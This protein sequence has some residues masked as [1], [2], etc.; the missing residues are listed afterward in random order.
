MLLGEYAIKLLFVI[1]PLLTNVSALPGETWTPEIVSF[2]SCCIACLENDTV[3]RTCCRL[4]L[5][6]G[7]KTVHCSVASQL[8]ERSRLRAERCEGARHR[9][10]TPAVLSANVL[11]VADGVRYR[12]CLKVGCTELFFV[13]PG[14]KWT[15][16]STARFRWRSRCFQ[17]CIA[18]PVTRIRVA[19]GQRT[20]AACSRDSPVAAEGEITIYLPRFV[21]S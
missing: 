2:H 1:P 12:C 4:R 17:S 3:F 11:L 20:G 14:W 16:D 7:R 8:A 10:W 5:L 9:C 19:A 6:L 18:L 15:A 21:A 13:K